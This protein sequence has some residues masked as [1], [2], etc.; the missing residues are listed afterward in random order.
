MKTITD[1]VKLPHGKSVS[2]IWNGKISI[3]G[4]GS[5]FT[6]FIQH[7]G[8]RKYI[9]IYIYI[10]II[11]C[12]IIFLGVTSMS[13]EFVNTSSAYDAV[14]HSNYDSYYWFTHFCDPGIV[15][16]SIF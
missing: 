16:M 2:S 8:I 9:S 4:S 6:G 13:V 5:D 12:L 15:P 10:H 7:I 1:E 3:L 14:Y 11:H